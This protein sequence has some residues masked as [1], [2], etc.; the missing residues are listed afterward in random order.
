MHFA[1]LK[2]SLLYAESQ[3]LMQRMATVVSRDGEMEQCLIKASKDVLE[4]MDVLLAKA[5]KSQNTF[6]ESF[7]GSCAS[8]VQWFQTLFT[9]EVAAVS[10]SVYD[11][12]PVSYRA[13]LEHL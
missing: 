11:S 5:V 9:Q 3:T 13:S 7:R 2:Y 1:G 8:L 12:G 10:K 6:R 4:Y